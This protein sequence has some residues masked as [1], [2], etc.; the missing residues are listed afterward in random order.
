[1][2]RAW[3]APCVAPKTLVTAADRAGF[4]VATRSIALI[5]LCAVLVPSRLLA[6]PSVYYVY[7]DLNRLV[8]VVDQQGNAATYTYDAVGNILKI[9]RF[10]ATGLLGGA[11]ISMFTPAAGAVGTTVQVFGRGFGT[12]ITQNSLLFG[13]RAATLVT[14]AP[15]RLVAKVPAG[16]TTGP[17]TVATPRGSATS[18]RVFR[19]LGELAITPQTVT[20]RVTGRVAFVVT[21]AG[22]PV[23]TVRWAVNG[24]TGGDPSV[25]TITTDGL[26]TAP[27]VMPVPPV[28][29]VTATH[30]DD[31]TLSASALVTILPGFPMLLAAR[32]VSVAAAVPPLSVDRSV[33]AAV[34]V[35]AE[36]PRGMTP[37]MSAAVSV[38]I[39]PVVLEVTPAVAAPG[40]TIVL[41]ITGRGL[42]GAI[43]VVFLRDNAADPSVAVANISVS[44]EG[45][46]ATAEITVGATASTGARV[47]QIATSARVSSPAGTG[48][49]VFTVR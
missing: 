46:Q 47:V 20:P 16:A 17:I 22:A 1:M 49:N 19:I 44:A 12:G 10:D 26:Y 30:A 31:A 2:E 15:N 40:D 43:A 28:V 18:S 45:T 27:A 8:A 21:E 3:P 23:A 35:R 6:Q 42:R 11:A 39:E 25:G 36:G 29:T 37:G 14:A 32:P 5:A 7:D 9:D 4:I 33:S 38:E 13:G 48:G 34:S 41:T 24:L